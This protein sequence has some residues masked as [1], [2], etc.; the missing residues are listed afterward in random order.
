[1]S[2]WAVT[3]KWTMVKV[4]GEVFLIKDRTIRNQGIP[5]TKVKVLLTCV[6]IYEAYT[7]G[8]SWLPV[9]FMCTAGGYN[10][11][12]ASIVKKPPSTGP[13]IVF[14]KQWTNRKGCWWWHLMGHI[15]NNLLIIF[16]E[17]YL[18]T[19]LIPLG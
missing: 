14:W 3:F 13:A 15:H 19:L 1:V 10:P 8:G 7:L 16:V 9:L 4:L 6:I 2:P 5:F 12:G 18:V 11:S 17:R